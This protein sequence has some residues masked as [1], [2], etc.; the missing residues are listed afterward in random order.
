MVLTA[1]DLMVHMQAPTLDGKL[2]VAEPA[3][4]RYQCCTPRP[5]RAPRPPLAP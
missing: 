1:Q 3:T 2:R 4:L 5:P